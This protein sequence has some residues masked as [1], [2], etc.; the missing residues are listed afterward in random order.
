MYLF[1][2]DTNKC[3]IYNK[4]IATE[5]RASY[6]GGIIVEEARECAEK[7]LYKEK[8]V[9]MVNEIENAG[10]LEYLYTFIKLFI[11]KWGY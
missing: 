9:E 3:S 2:V 6:I 7:I 8:I 1:Y 10:T 4:H 5:N 11:E